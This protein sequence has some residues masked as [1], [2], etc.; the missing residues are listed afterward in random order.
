MLRNLI[1]FL[2]LATLAGQLSAQIIYQ[3]APGGTI[4]IN[5]IS[6][7]LPAGTTRMDV[8]L[9]TIPGTSFGTVYKVVSG[10]PS[11]WG[12][13]F[14]NPFTVYGSLSTFN[15]NRIFAGQGFQYVANAGAALGSVDTI[16]VT[17]TDGFTTTPS[18]IQITIANVYYPVITQQ[19]TQNPQT[20]PGMTAQLQVAASIPTPPTTG[21]LTYQ[22]YQGIAPNASNPQSGATTPTFTWNVPGGQALGQYFFWCKVT[23]VG[24]GYTASL[25]GTVTVTNQTASVQSLVCGTNPTNAASIQYQLDFNA[26]GPAVGGLTASNFNLTIGG[27]LS[28]A[29]ITSVVSGLGGTAVYPTWFITVSTGTGDG[30]IRLNL[31]NSTG[32]TIGIS[33]LPYT[34]GTTVTVDKTRP[35][36]GSIT[37]TGSDPTNAAQVGFL[38][39]FTESVTGVSSANFTIATSGLS[40]TSIASV[41]GTGASRTVTVNTGS[42][43]GTLRLDVTASLSSIVDGVGNSMNVAYNTGQTYTI[44]KGA[45]TVTSI[46]L[47]GASPTAAASISFTVTFSESVTGVA[48]GNFSLTTGGVS[49]ASLGTIT[50]TGATRTVNVNT[51]SGS[52]T[53]RLDLSSTS[54]AISDGLGNTLTA[55]FNGGATCT[56]DK[57]PPTIGI[58]APSLSITGGSSVTFTVTY[59][60]ANFNSA[61]LT[62]GDITLN[63]TGT[64]TGTVAVTGS[65]TTRTVSI[66]GI[67]GNGTLGITI[68]AG[69][70]SDL[71]GNTAPAAGPSST[72]TVDTTPPGISIGAPS[73]A[74]TVGGPVTYTV[75]YSDASLS[76]VTLAPGDVSLNATGTATGTVGVSGTGNTR[77][78]TIS[79]ISGDGTL[80]I[81]IAAGTAI[82]GAGN[83]APAAGPATTFVADGTAPTISI[84]S[85]SVASTFSGPVTYDVTYSDANFAAATLAGADITLNTTGTATGTVTVTGTGTTRTVTISAITGDGTLGISVA[86]GTA[87]DLAGNAAPAAGPSATFVV[88][89]APLIAIGAP[90]ST[91]TGA[92][93]VDFT[94]TYTNATAVTLTS[95]DVTLATTGTVAGTVGVSGTGTTTR[96]ITVSAISGS[97]TFTISIAAGTAS[98]PGGSALAAGPST[99]V[100]VDN[101][102]PAI[103]AGATLSITQGGSG[104]GSTLATVS[105]NF[106]SAGN[107]V[108]T[109]TG[110]PAGITVSSISNTAGTVTGDVAVAATVAPGS[111]QIALTATDEA[112]NTAPANL[113]ITVVA[114]TAPTITA[115]AD[116][117]IAMDGNTGALTF[118]VDDADEGPAAL[119]VTFD[120]NNQILIDLLTDIVI[121]GSGA[122]R[123]I[124]VTPQAGHTGVA[125]ITLTVTDSNGATSSTSFT[126]TVTDTTD[127]PALAGLVNQTI[128]RDT[129]AG[130]FVFTATD[131]QGN[132]TLGAPSA[133]SANT[134]LIP[135]ANIVITGTAPNFSFTITPTAAMTGTADI[136]F[137]IDDGTHTTSRTIT[138]TV[139]DPPTGGGGGSDDNDDGCSTGTGHNAWMMLA[140]MLSTLVLATRMR[141]NA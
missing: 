94:I 126:L 105:D 24:Q 54:P 7:I 5:P 114:N 38:V 74:F 135:D 133:V 75:T 26:A 67:T 108:V 31:N 33:G 107:V 99:A 130:P 115:I 131:P 88:S 21:T 66:N 109:A 77:T 63:T 12:T 20:N 45:P 62:A 120:S 9:T 84:G 59:A 100:D 60:D 134:A 32:A 65:G 95:G 14:P 111:Y 69:T 8:G 79:A 125:L 2:L 122:N 49:G 57:T 25:T 118:D 89:G 127:A 29:N 1:A 17:Y 56:I 34:S 28:G 98:N 140:A 97:G 16:P 10:S 121:G 86:G 102:P 119:T 23:L 35:I 128:V 132:G 40:G 81:S 13:G 141:R 48:A 76:A 68:A 55:T 43:S 112:G 4:D 136:T 110:L 82:D 104:I 37:R 53:I 123:T 52:G 3:V 129:T 30:T 116:Q 42:G 72:F 19:P 27:S 36:V 96:T 46:T 83:V 64:A 93:P 90:S 103:T 101:T 91:L 138:V 15:E 73:A 61:T 113:G 18:S 80:G 106:S 44:D 58:G 39:S 87:T 124:T 92:G 78:V 85:P 6:Q 11:P 71:A 70:A 137:F 51:G 117:T 22:W 139:I 50:G 47:G 41:T